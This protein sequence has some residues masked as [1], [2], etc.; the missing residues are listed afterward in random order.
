MPIVAI[1]AEQRGQ[2][3][4]PVL[5]ARV[6]AGDRHAARALYDA[7]APR[8]HRLINRLTGD[9]EM[10][11]ELTQDTFVRAFAQLDRFRGDAALATWLHRIALSVTSNGLR[12][13]RRLRARESSLE[14]VT[15]E[16]WPPG[17]ARTDGAA[18]ALHA[19]GRADVDPDLRA[20]L[21]DAID[22]LPETLRVTLVMH[23]IEGYTH[24]EIA[25]ATGV[26]EGTSKSR[27]FDARARLR[28]ALAD[29]AAE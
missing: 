9:A 24:A 15:G 21:A 11:R 18:H 12:K 10:A 29:F 19:R 3:E 14:E 8:I 28:V 2:V 4:E 20:R 6:L 22:A 13:V 25:A 16:G 27:L 26:A 1:A 7:H 5:I 23:D 17:R